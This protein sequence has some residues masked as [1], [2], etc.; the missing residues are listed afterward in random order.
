MF[1]FVLK[2]KYYFCLPIEYIDYGKEKNIICLFGKYL[3]VVVGADNYA[4]EG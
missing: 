2:K 3:S 1:R 4:G